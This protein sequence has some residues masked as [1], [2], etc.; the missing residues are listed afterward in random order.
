MPAA[1]LLR[2]ARESAALTQTELGR[3]AG[4]SQSDISFVERGQ[5]SPSV[6]TLERLLGAS[7]HSLLAIPIVGPD[8]STTGARIES[9]IGSA[10]TDAALR[11]LIDYSDALASVYG[12]DRIA[13]TLARPARTGAAVWDA[14]LAA[15]A[16]HWLSELGLPQPGWVD[17]ADRYLANLTEPIVYPNAP[18]IDR[19]DIPPAFLRRNVALE[20]GT[21]ESV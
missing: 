4:T 16:D 8:A 20:R 7:Q 18:R 11:A 17:E 9:A 19:A 15:V 3:R 1:Q 14:A 10:R 2:A 5:R 12:T 13:L 21:L 6:A